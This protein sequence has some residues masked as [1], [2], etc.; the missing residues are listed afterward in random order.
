MELKTLLELLYSAADPQPNR[1][2]DG[3]PQASAGARA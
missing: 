2:S 3:S 1:P